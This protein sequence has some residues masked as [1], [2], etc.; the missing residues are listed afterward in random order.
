MLGAPA[1]PLTLDPTTAPSVTDNPPGRGATASG[2]HAANTATG[3][4]TSPFKGSAFICH[5][6]SLPDYDPRG[7]GAVGLRGK[8]PRFLLRLNDGGGGG[9]VGLIVQNVLTLT[10]ELLRR[11]GKNNKPEKLHVE[12]SPSAERQPKALKLS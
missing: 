8:L 4:R 9:N 11:G 3:S 6:W 7:G 2:V 12:R 5:P 10:A 1:P